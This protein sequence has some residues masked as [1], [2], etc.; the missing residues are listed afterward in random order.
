[1]I[2]LFIIVLFF[3]HLFD[4]EGYTREINSWL[5]SLKIFFFQSILP[6]FIVLIGFGIIFKRIFGKKNSGGHH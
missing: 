1:V 6:T 4:A 2:V 3:W 5:C